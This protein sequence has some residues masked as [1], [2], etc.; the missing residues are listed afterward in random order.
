[1]VLGMNTKTTA[2][3]TIPTFPGF[4]ELLTVEQV[5]VQVHGSR[6]FVETLIRRGDLRAYRFGSRCTRV[7]PTSVD[8]YLAR[9]QQQSA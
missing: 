8:E 2:T 3:A 6:S 9:R 5:A 4:D 1:M 7:D